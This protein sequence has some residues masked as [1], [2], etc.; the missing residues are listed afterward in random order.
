MGARRATRSGEFGFYESLA[1]HEADRGLARF[2]HGR[3]RRSGCQTLFCWA[4]ENRIATVFAS[5][6]KQLGDQILR[7][8]ASRAARAR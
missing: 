7:R 2:V 6:L 5:A 3:A 1:I 8:F 4:K